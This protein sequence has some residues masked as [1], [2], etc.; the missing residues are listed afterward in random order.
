MATPTPAS[1]AGPPGAKTRLFALS[2]PV[3]PERPTLFAVT[4]GAASPVG[5]TVLVGAPAEGSI[6]G[7]WK[8][9]AAATGPIT[10]GASPAATEAGIESGAPGL[11][12]DPWPTAE[13]AAVGSAPPVDPDGGAALSAPAEALVTRADNTAGG[14][15][16]PG[17]ASGV[18]AS[19]SPPGVLACLRPPVSKPVP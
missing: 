8:R 7:G 3:S 15:S 1:G 2:T 18:P 12:A 5:G 17:P 16:N 14:P 13:A 10:A 6:G 11:A 9:A 4:S 19:R